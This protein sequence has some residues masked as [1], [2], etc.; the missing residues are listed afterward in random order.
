[1]KRAKAGQRTSAYLKAAASG[2]R[3]D[4]WRSIWLIHCCICASSGALRCCRTCRRS[5]GGCPR[6]VRSMAYSA[7]MR[8]MASAAIGERMSCQMS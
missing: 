4:T 3:L 2:E 8:P 7:P 1:M 6:M 5:A